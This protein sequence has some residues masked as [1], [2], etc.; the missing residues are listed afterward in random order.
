[1]KG[2]LY[3]RF[4]CLSIFSICGC[5]LTTAVYAQEVEE[6]KTKAAVDA[7]S[8]QIDKK[9]A[10]VKELE[11]LVSKYQDRIKSQEA[12]QTTLENELLIL[13]NRVAK[14]KLDIERTKLQLETIGLEMRVLDDRIT[15]QSARVIRLQGYAADLIRD[16]HQSDSVSTFHILLSQRSLSEFFDRLEEKKKLERNLVDSMEKVKIQKKEMEETKIQKNTKKNELEREQQILKKEELTLEAEKNFKTSLV[17]ETRMKQDEFERILYELQQQQQSTSQDISDLEA[18]LKDKLD[19]IDVALS[20]GDVLLNW[21][22]DPSRGI[23]ATFHDPSYPFKKLFEHPGTDIRASVGTPIKSAAGGY[24]AWN[25]K[26][27][28]YGNYIMV[29]HPGNVATVYAHLSK[30]VAGQDTYVQRG[31]TIGLTGGMPGMAGAGLS[32]GPHLHFEVRQDGVPVNPENYL[33]SVR[34]DD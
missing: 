17:S 18:K 21:P 5:L 10:R 2:F 4:A 14:K 22:V 29:V 23:T 15:Q 9:Q 32:T 6:L 11:A 7:L 28:L 27:R 16:I 8:T 26:G 34:L 33:P 31:E 12:Q 30:F 1:M 19:T 20:R 13:D 25:K 24:V 3:F